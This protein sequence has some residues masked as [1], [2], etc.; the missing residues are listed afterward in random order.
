M[1]TRRWHSDG[2]DERDDDPENV[3]GGHRDAAH[4][5]DDVLFGFPTHA[6]MLTPK[7]P[8]RW[9]A[10]RMF[11]AAIVVRTHVPGSDEV[12]LSY[13][14]VLENDEGY[15]SAPIAQRDSREAAQ[16]LADALNA[17]MTAN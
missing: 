11:V 15:V 4:P 2:V 7:K 17:A 14:V 9:Y 6:A 5:G 13:P 3:G 8:V 1:V 10:R 12:T 16:K